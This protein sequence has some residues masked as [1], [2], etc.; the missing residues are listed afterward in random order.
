MNKKV[1]ITGTSQGLGRAIAEQFL[2]E[3]AFVFGC[4][5]GGHSIN[6]DNYCHFTLD[7]SNDIQVSQMFKDIKSRQMSLD[8]L[9]NNASLLYSGIA[10]FTSAAKIKELI[11]VNLIGTFFVTREALKL[12]QL[13]GYGRII[14]FSSINVEAGWAGGAVYNA[15]KAGVVAMSK[16]LVRE[17]VGMDI[18]INTLGLSFAAGGGMTESIDPKVLAQKQL[19]LIKPNLLEVDE[20]MHAIDFFSSPLAKNISCQTLY[21]GGL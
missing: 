9:I 7:I 6:H 2:E 8:L 3:G 10:A 4:S 11:D 16:S 12:M 21:F 15:S 1:L 17:C 13:N 14:N 5:R 20:I 18:T 19:E